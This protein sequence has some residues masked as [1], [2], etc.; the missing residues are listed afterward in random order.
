MAAQYAIVFVVIFV[1]PTILTGSFKLWLRTR[2]VAYLLL[3][4]AYL[5]AGLTLVLDILSP[6][7]VPLIITAV[8]QGYWLV[9]WKADTEG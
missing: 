5:L 2:H 3:P 7:L 4:Y 1:W 9:T 8:V 6:L